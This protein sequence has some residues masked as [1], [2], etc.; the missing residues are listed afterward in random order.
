M[1][2]WPVFTLI[3]AASVHAKV[4]KKR[5]KT[6]AEN[7]KMLRFIITILS[8]ILIYILFASTF[9]DMQRSI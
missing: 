7:F 6:E 1:A 9:Q 2:F 5:L 8:L 4:R 3:L